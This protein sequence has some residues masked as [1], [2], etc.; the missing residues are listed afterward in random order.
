M[1]TIVIIYVAHY[2]GLGCYVLALVFMQSN[3][4]P[5][6]PAAFAFMSS[7]LGNDVT[8]DVYIFIDAL[9]SVCDPASVFM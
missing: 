7:S 1:W 9:Q 6:L 8:L 4:I 3:V 5:Y 2:P